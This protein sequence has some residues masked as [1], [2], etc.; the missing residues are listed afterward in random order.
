MIDYITIMRK[1]ILFINSAVTNER[2]DKH[3]NDAKKH[4]SKSQTV[5]YEIYKWAETLYL[6][7]VG[8]FVT[9]YII[10]TKLQPSFISMLI[11]IAI[12]FNQT[13]IIGEGGFTKNKIDTLFWCSYAC[14]NLTTIDQYRNGNLRILPLKLIKET[15]H[16]ESVL[17][18][19]DN[20]ILLNDYYKS[21]FVQHDLLTW[22]NRLLHIFYTDLPIDDIKAVSELKEKFKLTDDDITLIKQLK[23]GNMTLIKQLAK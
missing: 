17:D 15:T 2:I 7:V 12:F 20:L 13:K 1:I 23:N 6:T 16:I 4:L 11:A 9:G 5:I 21:H 18:L 22:V 3:V 14:D 8:M 10:C 19:T